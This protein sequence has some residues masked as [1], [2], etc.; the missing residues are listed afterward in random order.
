M[1][2]PKPISWTEQIQI[3]PTIGQDVVAPWHI[4]GTLSDTD[5]THGGDILIRAS[6][7]A[8]EFRVTVPCVP[9]TIDR[10]EQIRQGVE[11]GLR[12]K[13]ASHGG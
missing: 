5:P 2:D 1:H 11:R 12:L 8:T 4:F 6:L 9:W 7:G 3:T 10:L 13:E